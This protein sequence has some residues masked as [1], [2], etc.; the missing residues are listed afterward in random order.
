MNP[1]T[2]HP[3]FRLVVLLV[4]CL[5]PSV[6][7]ALPHF[8]CFYVFGDSLADNGNVLIQ[9]AAMR[10]DPPAPPSAT[11]HQTYFKGRFSNGYIGFEYLWQGL[12][13]HKPGSAHGLKPFLAAPFSQNGCA[14][15]FAFGGTGTPYVDQTP[16]GFYAP[17]LRGQV[18]LFRLTL[19]G[20]KPSN[21][22]LYAIATGANDY[23]NDPFN[24]PMNPAD[25][26]RN[27][28]ETI[29]SLYQLGARNVM[30]LDL[31]DLGLIPANLS[32]PDPRVSPA[33]TEV[34]LAHN[35]ALDSS[36]DHLQPRYP[37][38]HLI[39]VKLDPLFNE[40]RTGTASRDPMESHVPLIEAVAQEATPPIPPGMSA[41]LFLDPASCVN[42]PASS[43]NRNFG[44]IFWDVV[45]PTTEAYRLLGDY[46][47]DL[48][49]GEY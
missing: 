21:R 1:T 3:L 33:A 23:R 48:L 6:A 44:F 24:V 39:R 41:C 26:V 30:V 40:L 34:S 19:R 8:D 4:V 27:I 25:V 20:K 12:T 42:M 46:M 10:M 28:E 38:L 43:F 32:H 47:Y 22:S 29:V 45:H 49:A 13:G 15:D 37:Q 36:L 7:T 11:P 31:P 35:A 14:V 17:G 5:L 2:A 9:T 16:G 18:E